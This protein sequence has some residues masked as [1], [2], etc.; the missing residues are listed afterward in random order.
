ML[1]KIARLCCAGG[2]NSVPAIKKASSTLQDKEVERA[3]S[4]ADRKETSLNGSSQA[5]SVLE[6]RA[7][8]QP[9][10][11]KSEHEGVG[12]TKG[13][14][15]KEFLEFRIVEF[16][17]LE[18]GEPPVPADSYEGTL[19]SPGFLKSMQNAPKD[20]L[21]SQISASLLDKVETADFFE[22]LQTRIFY[23]ERALNRFLL[24]DEVSQLS[25]FAIKSW[26]E[27]DPRIVD[28]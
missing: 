12:E 3:T 8:L 1:S 14:D 21:W 10:D 7:F 18:T 4:E 17:P 11:L 15:P 25:S 24:V 19:T 2:E 13:E 16:Q 23:L 6:S 27:N 5:R 9:D 26:L 22:A 20:T 28:A